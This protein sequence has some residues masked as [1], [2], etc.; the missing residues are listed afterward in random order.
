MTLDKAHRIA[1]IATV[2]TFI[3]TGVYMKLRFPELYGGSEFVHVMYRSN[4]IYILLA[5]LVNVGLGLY[6]AA[7]PP[8]WR[9]RVQVA[10]SALVMAAPILLA[11]AFFRDPPLASVHRVITTVGIV[12]LALGMLGH[13]VARP[14]RG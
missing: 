12:T 11:V 1:G 2:G 4:H 5:G 9:G 14:R 8:G 10:G 7:R 13:V 3:F 6:L